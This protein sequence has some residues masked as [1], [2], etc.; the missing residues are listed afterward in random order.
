MN[1]RINADLQ[2]QDDTQRLECEKIHFQ[3][4]HYYFMHFD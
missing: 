2:K 1:M 4:E 3:N